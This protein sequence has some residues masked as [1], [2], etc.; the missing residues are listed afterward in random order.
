M[1]TVVM[2]KSLTFLK[3]AHL[4][5]DIKY[6]KFGVEDRKSAWYRDAKPTKDVDETFNSLMK[7]WLLCRQEKCCHRARSS[8]S[9][10]FLRKELVYCINLT[11]AFLF[12]T[13]LI[14]IILSWK[15]SIPR[16]KKMSTTC[17]TCFKTFHDSGYHTAE[18]KLSQHC[19]S[20]GH[21]IRPHSSGPSR[22]RCPGC[23]KTFHEGY[24]H[25]APWWK[26]ARHMASTGHY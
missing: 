20:T 7:W 15:L 12:F 2:Q 17:P 23:H 19:C 18:R 21:S 9:L 10:K 4:F 25:S 26:V 24:Y 22:A 13:L 16:Y 8:G 6:N 3:A 11:V 5:C 1:R 14:A